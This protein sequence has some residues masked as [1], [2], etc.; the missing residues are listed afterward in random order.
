MTKERSFEFGV[1]ATSTETRRALEV[2]AR[3]TKASP[4]AEVRIKITEQADGSSACSAVLIDLSRSSLDS[5]VKLLGDRM[6]YFRDVT[7]RERD[8]RMRENNARKKTERQE[9]VALMR[10]NDA[11]KKTERQEKAADSKAKNEAKVA[12]RKASFEVKVAQRNASRAAAEPKM[13]AERLRQGQRDRPAPNA[14]GH[15]IAALPGSVR[16]T[17]S[18]HV[19]SGERVDFFL[20][21]H[22]D[23]TLV[24]LADRLLIL[25]PGFM[26]NTAFGCRATTLYYRDVTGIQIN[27]GMRKAVLEVSTPSYQATPIDYWRGFD[28][29]VK[30]QVPSAYVAPNCIPANKKLV[31]SWKPLLDELRQRVAAAKLPIHEDLRTDPAAGQLD[32]TEQIRKLAALRD[33]GILTAEEF[34]DK[35]RQILDR[36]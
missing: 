24:A 9:K 29:N 19:E 12:Q 6:T 17:A 13:Q 2:Y 5:I 20:V 28:K 36:I 25:K 14:E 4:E 7:R 3:P 35:K 22:A 16:K 23:Q 32:P 34:E 10:E 18:Q 31:D 11:R 33:D 21:G 8:A 30:A 27:T 26:A 1:S 15:E